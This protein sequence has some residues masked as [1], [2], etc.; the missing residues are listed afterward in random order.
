M[1]IQCDRCAIKLKG[2]F[3]CK[4]K[5]TEFLF[6]KKKKPFNDLCISVYY[7]QSWQE[8]NQLR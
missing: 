6:I 4:N 7:T 8:L 2:R 5:H 1:M 3:L